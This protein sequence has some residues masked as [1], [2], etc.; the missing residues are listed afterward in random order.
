MN[1]YLRIL[2]IVIFA[3]LT[4]GVLWK[5]IEVANGLYLHSV[6]S[7]TQDNTAADTIYHEVKIVGH[8]AN[9]GIYKVRHGISYFELLNKAGITNSS[10]ISDIML[11]NRIESNRIIR[12]AETETPVSAAVANQKVRLEF[13]W[14]SVELVSR[15]GRSMQPQPGTA[16]EEGT[17][18]ITD[19]NA[20]T[21]ISLN[22][23]SRVDIDELSE[24]T[25]EKIGEEKEGNV[26]TRLFQRSGMGWFDIS[27]RNEKERVK[28]TTRYADITVAEQGANFTIDAS[29]D[30][31]V[32]HT[33][34]GLLLVERKR[35]DEAI[36]LISGQQV[37][38]YSDDRPFQ[39]RSSAVQ[40][41][42][43]EI[44]SPLTR[45]KTQYFL[46]RRPFNFMF[47]GIP[48]TYYLISAD[49]DRRRATV[50][51]VA[52]NT[53]VDRFAQGVSTVDQ[54]L[55]KA[56]P[57]FVNTLIE[58][59][60]NVRIRNYIM[61]NRLDILQIAE[62]LGS[63]PV[64]VDAKAAGELNIRAG[65]QKLTSQQLFRF[66]EP[67]VS[68]WQ[69]SYERQK[70]VL[71][72]LFN[73][74][75]TQEIVLRSVIIRQLLAETESNFNW[76]EVVDKYSKFKSQ[77]GWNFKYEQLPVSHTTRDNRTYLIPDLKDA[78][79]LLNPEG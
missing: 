22:A 71:Q 32:V 73:S 23:Y 6:T 64:R 38:V 67:G 36:N 75:S 16:I 26:I 48:H 4:A 72:A 28:I 60:M 20:Q 1:R 76:K 68:G 45:K 61:L 59:I 30:K 77:T 46:K 50:V 79:N 51:H 74:L 63:V 14:G 49:F 56:G 5:A 55:L 42:P 66:L 24:I 18:I 57:A 10:D 13:F 54:A 62:T 69:G 27:Y 35:T 19:A 39:V 41:T 11:G 3:A 33:I 17:R 53:S 25:V 2:K 40:K 52:P 8:V 12:V 34:D 37:T 43:E 44:F 31:I 78:R 29:Y 65:R 7:R 47:I 15:D 21:E 9:P 70:R 58:E